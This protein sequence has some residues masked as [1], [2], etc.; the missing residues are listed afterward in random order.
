MAN[1]PTPRVRVPAQA[2]PGE[3]IE[4]KTLIS[5]EMESG[6][7]K[8]ASGKVVPR[9]IINTFT[10]EFNGK[11][12]FEADWNPAISANPYQSFYYKA[13]ETGEF[14]FTWKDDDGSNYVAKKK[15]TVA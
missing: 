13:A 4:I 6:Q 5:H 8:D 9:K 12:F 10:A 1:A 3:V 14:T 15:M 2:K 11:Q 7:R